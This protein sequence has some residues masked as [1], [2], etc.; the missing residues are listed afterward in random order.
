MRYM[1]YL[2]LFESYEET[3]D[4]INK[5]V[6]KFE[7]EKEKKGRGGLS[8]KLS[9]CCSRF[10]AVFEFRNT[11]EYPRQDA[12]SCISATSYDAE[13]QHMKRCCHCPKVGG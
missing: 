6:D 5:L 8:Q 1:K 7:S 13:W 9:E 10:M 4:S 11:I 3:A 2:K 12:L